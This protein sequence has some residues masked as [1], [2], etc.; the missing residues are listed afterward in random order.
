[1]DSAGV[2]IYK[3]PATTCTPGYAQPSVAAV[4]E[5]WQAKGPFGKMGNYVRSIIS[6]SRSVK[7]AICSLSM[8]VSSKRQM[9]SSFSANLGYGWTTVA[10]EDASLLWLAPPPSGGSYPL[11]AMAK[12]WSS[13]MWSSWWLGK[14][15]KDWGAL[16]IALLKS[17]ITFYQAIYLPCLIFIIYAA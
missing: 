5:T 1:M 6:S 17:G 2:N 16:Q 10:G 9:R 11:P 8:R 15:A 12:L 7:T 4:G 14:V 13:V 3:P